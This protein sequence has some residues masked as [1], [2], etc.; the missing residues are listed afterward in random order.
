MP[1]CSV[2]I[3]ELDPAKHKLN[4]RQLLL[5]EEVQGL[6]NA[7]PVERL[8]ALL[9]S[10][11]T[12]RGE[13]DLMYARERAARF[14]RARQAMAGETGRMRGQAG[15]REMQG[16]L[17]K[18]TFESPE[19]MFTPEEL[20]GIYDQSYF[21][22]Q[23]NPDAEGLHMRTHLALEKLFLGA[24]PQPN[25]IDLLGDVFG[26]KIVVELQRK[27]ARP[28]AW[29]EMV[30]LAGASRTFL[31]T[32]VPDFS[33][34]GRQG[35]LAVGT[36]KEYLGAIPTYLKA[37][38]RQDVQ[39]ALR[40]VTRAD[41]LYHLAEQSKLALPAFKRTAL[42]AGE[43]EEFLM[44]SERTFVG[45]LLHNF[46]PVRMAQ[47][48]YETFLS[49]YRF[50]AWKANLRGAGVDVDQIL[51]G[52]MATPE[53][54]TK[55]Q[56]LAN[57]INGL[58]GRGS[59]GPAESWAPAL[60]SSLFSARNFAAKI[61]VPLSTVHPTNPRVRRLALQGLVGY[62]GL[63]IGSLA[64]VKASGLADVEL[65]PRSTDFG[66]MRLGPLRI[67]PSG[68]YAPIIRLV[69]RVATGETKL[70]TGDIASM[71]RGEAVLRFGRS[72][73]SPPVGFMWDVVTGETAIGE[74]VTAGQQAY[75]RLVPITLQD[76]RDAVHE[77]GWQQ[78][79]IAGPLSVL[80]IGTTSYR[81]SAEQ[82]AQ[83]F[84]EEQGHDYDENS[85]D[86]REAMSALQRELHEGTEPRDLTQQ[87]QQDAFQNISQEF[88][89]DMADH[90]AALKRYYETGGQHGI[91]PK[92]W[93]DYLGTQQAEARGAREEALKLA[94]TEFADRPNGDLKTRALDKYFTV[95]IGKFTDPDTL[96]VNWED[97]LA[98]QDKAFAGLSTTDEN[99]LRDYI[100]R[101]YETEIVTQIRHMRQ[102]MEADISE[103]YDQKVGSA[104]TNYRLSHPRLDALL[105]ITAGTKWVLTAQARNLST[106][107]LRQY[108]QLE[109]TAPRDP[110]PPKRS[111]PTQP[112]RPSRPERPERPQ[113]P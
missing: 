34:I 104:R 96:E 95:D 81:S 60:N 109:G 3:E 18:I 53:E 48:G 21:H 107:L 110:S 59:L 41:P 63:Y 103:Y 50:D 33:A 76:I 92:A 28:S 79:V 6:T 36:P 82:T 8:T 80:G 73:A 54:L 7:D 87:A 86:D 58:S 77:G 85:F 25:E 35:A 93:K 1:L 65:D 89:A 10:A 100:K 45:R 97:Y 51:A 70:S 113:R 22:W 9:K 16:E 102:D 37:T 29:E 4:R 43:H 91:G 24:V 13:Q 67:D 15:L 62:A 94:G 12:L 108:M 14:G 47:R 26:K 19:S 38:A 75:Q 72:K 32:F 40:D 84:L 20:H 98:A 111:R 83:R 66:K 88:K 46:P 49:K 57:I 106:Q 101:N 90:D 71:N 55:S 17:P 99:E 31:S 39:D 2:P 30:A 78:G 112:S 44:A 11:K 105:W 68:G 23:G 56:Q 64:A 74:E 52:R 42:T 5:A 61:Q 69:A 27:M